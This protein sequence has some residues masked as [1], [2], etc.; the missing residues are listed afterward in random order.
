MLTH[1][2]IRFSVAPMMDWT[3]R[4][5]RYFHRLLSRRARLYTEMLTTGAVIHGDRARLMAFDPFE[6]PVAMQLGGAE[7]AALATVGGSRRKIRLCGGQSQRRLSVGSRARRR[8]RRL[9]HARACAR[10]RLHQG[11]EGRR[12]HS[13]HGEMP[14]R[15]RRSGPGESAVRACRSLRRKRRRRAVRACAKGLAQGPL[16]KGKPRRSAAWTIRSCTV[17][18]A[19]CRTFRSPS[20]AG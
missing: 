7:P 3:D 16:A 15:R 20:M 2:H 8:V 13:R 17:S 14:H 12:R 9:S 1:Q 5:C 18:S 19:P 4:H 6:Q 10:R 11:D